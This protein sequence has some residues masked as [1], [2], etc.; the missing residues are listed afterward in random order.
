MKTTKPENSQD[1]ASRLEF[2]DNG[3]RVRDFHA[4]VLAHSDVYING[5]QSKYYKHAKEFD[6]KKLLAEFDKM[7]RQASLYK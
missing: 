2:D 4:L 3:N 5:N 7:P 6:D 1:F